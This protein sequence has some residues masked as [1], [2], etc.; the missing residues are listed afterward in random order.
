MSASAS[1]SP[2]TAT[3]SRTKAA[4]A[5]LLLILAAPA[6]AG[7]GLGKDSTEET[8]KKVAQIKRD[9]SVDQFKE[10]RKTS[11]EKDV[12]SLLDLA[13]KAKENPD[14]LTVGDTKEAQELA[15][16]VEETCKP[17]MK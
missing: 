5:G 12:N 16:K 2:L 15:K 9:A 4:A 17:H 7:C 14:S 3:A 13:I 6:L 10:V 11:K 8:C 1:L